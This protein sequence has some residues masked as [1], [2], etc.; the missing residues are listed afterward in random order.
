MEFLHSQEGF[1]LIFREAGAIA[2]FPLPEDMGK[3]LRNELE[4]F[5][6]VFQQNLLLEVLPE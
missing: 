1:K 4:N 3:E 5:K 6:I 2:S